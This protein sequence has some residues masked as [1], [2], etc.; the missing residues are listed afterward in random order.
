[1][2]SS[3]YYL[4]LLLLMEFVGF[5]SPRKY[6][7]IKVGFDILTVAPVGQVSYQFLSHMY[8]V[9]SQIIHNY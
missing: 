2:A 5:L 4:G 1:M 3:I 6:L 9:Y 8:F 7:N